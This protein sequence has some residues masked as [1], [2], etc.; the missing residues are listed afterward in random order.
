MPYFNHDSFGR[1]VQEEHCTFWLQSL[2]R[3]FYYLFIF[4]FFFN[5]LA[6]LVIKRTLGRNSLSLKWNPVWSEYLWDI[7][8]KF[9]DGQAEACFCLL[10]YLRPWLWTAELTL[11]LL[12]NKVSP[13]LPLPRLH[14]PFKPHL[15]TP[16]MKLSL[17]AAWGPVTTTLS[18]FILMGQPAIPMKEMSLPP[19]FL[20]P[21]EFWILMKLQIAQ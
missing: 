9:G 18:L 6:T 7:N 8:N 13:A 12:G 5:F 20:F 17:R 1:T 11:T 15:R 16:E 21:Q 10:L 14:P 4:Y 3:I 19:W 2:C